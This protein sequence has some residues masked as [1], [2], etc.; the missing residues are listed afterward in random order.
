MSAA[1]ASLKWVSEVYRAEAEAGPH[2]LPT[3]RHGIL[4]G[5]WEGERAGT[6]FAYEPRNPATTASE[7]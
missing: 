2:P 1:R 5:G 7:R 4:V 6:D 3:T